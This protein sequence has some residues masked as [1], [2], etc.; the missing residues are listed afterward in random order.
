MGAK[1][2]ELA[3]SGRPGFGVS[4]GNKQTFPMRRIGRAKRL[5]AI[6]LISTSHSRRTR[7]GS[8]RYSTG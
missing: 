3:G 2:P 5:I 1:R 4:N 7:V 6:E 8:D